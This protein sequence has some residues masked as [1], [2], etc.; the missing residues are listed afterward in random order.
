MT[1]IKTM[2]N[3]SL[4]GWPKGQFLNTLWK[5]PNASFGQPNRIKPLKMKQYLKCYLNVQC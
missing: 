1:I 2:I 3:K 5:N 4:L